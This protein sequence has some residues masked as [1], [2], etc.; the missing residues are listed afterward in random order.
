MPGVQG[1][2]PDHVECLLRQLA[3]VAHQHLVHV[4]VMAVGN[5]DVLQT[6]V[7]LVCS[8]FGTGVQMMER[9]VENTCTYTHTQNNSLARC[10]GTIITLC[11][12]K[13][14]KNFLPLLKF[15]WNKLQV[16]CE[17]LMC[18]HGKSHF[19]EMANNIGHN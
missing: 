8:I 19:P 18:C 11:Y 2:E 14:M 1:V 9:G 16:D 6:T 7:G 4:L 12:T 10:L 5:V 3:P 15:Y 13:V 17:L